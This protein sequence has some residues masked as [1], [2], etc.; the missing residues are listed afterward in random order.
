MS[1]RCMAPALS[2]LS[3]SARLGLTATRR[4]AAIVTIRVFI[5]S[6]MSSAQ[7]AVHGSFPAQLAHLHDPGR[8]G[9]LRRHDDGLDPDRHIILDLHGHARRLI[10]DLPDRE[11]EGALGHCDLR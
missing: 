1:P 8:L 2:T 10:A 4:A 5:M 11:V 6:S 9:V 3:S 7:V